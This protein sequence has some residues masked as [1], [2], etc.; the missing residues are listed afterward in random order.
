MSGP[1]AAV[2]NVTVL[3][4]EGSEND[5]LAV[6][7]QKGG[8]CGRGGGEVEQGGCGHAGCESQLGA[9]GERREGKYLGGAA[10]RHGVWIGS[11]GGK[12]V[13]EKDV[14]RRSESGQIFISP[15]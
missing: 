15:E 9:G 6:G 11:R 8:E 4:L 10:T 5:L 12:L 2:G 3:F 7:P 14:V 1:R 13:R